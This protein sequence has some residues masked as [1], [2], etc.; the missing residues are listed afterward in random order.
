MINIADAIKRLK[1]EVSNPSKGLPDDLFHYISSTTPII[2]VDLLLKDKNGRTLLSWRNDKFHEQGWHVPGGIIRFKETIK[3]RIN[4]VARIE[5]GTF[6]DS[7]NPEPI[8]INEVFN[9]EHEVRSHFISLLYRCSLS[10]DFVPENKGLSKFDPGY[11][12][13]HKSCPDDL[14][15]LH[16]IYRKYL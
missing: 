5:I 3:E 4:E 7:Y 10:N 16:E 15:K 6:L 2:N 11:L 9:H 1:Q 12:M 13:W 8:A 14:L